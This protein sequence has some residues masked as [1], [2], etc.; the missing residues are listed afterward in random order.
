MEDTKQVEKSAGAIEIKMAR[1]SAAPSV[2]PWG[3][4]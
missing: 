3:T 4:V 2:I 1:P